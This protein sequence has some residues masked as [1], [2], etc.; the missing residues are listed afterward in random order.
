MSKDIL[1]AFDSGDI[2]GISALIDRLEQSS[3]DYLKL[4][5][6]GVSVTIGKNGAGEV[7]AAGVPA[8]A[9]VPAAD[10]AQPPA[11]SETEAPRP[12]T[13]VPVAEQEGVTIVRSPSYGLFYAQSEP[14]APPY[15]KIGDKVG[16]GDTVGLIEIMK[17]F[18]AIAAPKNGE[19]IAIHVK[20]EELL[21]P[22][23]PLVSIKTA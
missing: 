2:E 3:F 18:N 10:A 22:G 8:A 7:F 19:V 17:T 16:A 14:G 12:V 20:N 15:V 1:N 5:G 6:G 21:E 4:E 9:A 23:Q 13:T 11:V